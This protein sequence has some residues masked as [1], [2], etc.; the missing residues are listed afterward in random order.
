MAAYTPH[1]LRALCRDGLPLLLRQTSGIDFA[2]FGLNPLG[3][4]FQL[5]L[6]ANVTP[7]ALE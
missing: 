6:G 2:T 1:S 4:F 5:M 3:G 7:A